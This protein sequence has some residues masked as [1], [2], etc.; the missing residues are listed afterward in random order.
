VLLVIFVV[1]AR[2]ALLVALTG[3]VPADLPAMLAESYPLLLNHILV[4]IFFKVDVLLLQVIKGSEAVG[5]YSA[6]YKWLDG[7]LIVPSTFT[8]A[9]YPALSRFAREKGEGLRAAY[10]VSVRILLCLGVPIAIGIAFL[11]GD[12]ILLLGGDAYYPQSAVA[13][14]I[15]IWFLPFSYVNGL[16]QYALIAVHRQRFITAAFILAAGFNLLANLLF[17]PRYSFYAASAVT[18]LSEIVVMV[19][20]LLAARS[21]IGWP[22]WTRAAG[23]PALAGALM[24]LIAYAGRP[25]EPHLALLVGAGAYVGAIGALGVFTSDE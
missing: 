23:K 20:F 12:L 4:T 13:L 17:I 9:V 24:A 25:V 8:F 3:P 18:V 2:R 11:S 10:D 7:L 15:L 21:S 16:T 22:N 14:L 1:A 19:P 5:Y 6:A